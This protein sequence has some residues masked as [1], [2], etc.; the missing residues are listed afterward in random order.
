MLPPP[1]VRNKP[2][3][4]PQ[5]GNPAGRLREVECVT[6]EILDGDEFERC[7]MGRTQNH[8]GRTAGFKSF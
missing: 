7:L 4:R 5:R 3:L 6:F 8:A 2:V 1:D